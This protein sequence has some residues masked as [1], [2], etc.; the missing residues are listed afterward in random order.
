M[1]DPI[2]IF[3]AAPIF[4]ALGACSG[5]IY[6][7]LR[8]AVSKIPRE[9]WSARVLSVICDILFMIDATVVFIVSLY[10]LNSGVFRLIF[11]LSFALGF[12]AYKLTL[13]RAIL[14][15]LSLFV[16]IIAKCIKFFSRP[17][18]FSVRMLISG[19]RKIFGMLAKIKARLYNKDKQAKNKS[20][21]PPQ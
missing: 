17:I 3:K 16:T 12:V 14:K 19:A 21:S 18:C 11:L 9:K 10:Y 5:V 2:L 6:D 7:I 20:V 13:S 4:F 8:F 1:Y 15:I